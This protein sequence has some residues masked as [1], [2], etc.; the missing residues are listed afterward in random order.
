LKLPRVMEKR[1]QKMPQVRGA[2]RVSFL[3]GVSVDQ[4]VGQYGYGAVFFVVMLQSADIPLPGDTI[5]VTAF[6]LALVGSA[7][8]ANLR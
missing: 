8:V 5:L 4:F 6:R 3:D 7:G 2:C 1:R